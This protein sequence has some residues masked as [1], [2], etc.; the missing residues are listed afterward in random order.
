[1]NLLAPNVLSAE[2]E[3]PPSNVTTEEQEVQTKARV[4]KAG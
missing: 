3:R 4:R 1:M 2:A